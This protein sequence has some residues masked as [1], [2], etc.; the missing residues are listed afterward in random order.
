VTQT[1]AGTAWYAYAVVGPVTPEVR[2][3]L[4]DELELVEADGLGV[5]V[6][7]VPLSEFGEDVLSARL[8]DRAWL[9]EKARAHEAVLQRLLPVTTVVPLRFGSIHRDR[10]AVAEFAIARRRSFAETLERLRGRVELGVKVW[11]AAAPRAGTGERPATGR[12]YLEQQKAARERAAAAASDLDERLRD[13]HVR[14]LAVA[15]AGA[16]SR[17]QPRELTGTDRTMLVN[18]AYLV[19]AGDDRLVGEVARLR[20]EHPD[21]AFEVTGPWAPYNFVEAEAEA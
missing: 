18:A 9:E 5:V 12:A 8:N 16:L 13:I 10:S 1:A 20:D 17:P 6:S 14:L 3:A 19:G 11:G 7:Q 2:D 21:L 15:D 4:A